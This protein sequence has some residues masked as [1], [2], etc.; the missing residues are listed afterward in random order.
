MR[1]LILLLT[2]LGLTVYA[3]L[4]PTQL[5]GGNES[6]LSTTFNFDLSNI[7]VTRN[8]TSVQFGTIP[9]TQGGTSAT[10]LTQYSLMSG[11]GTSAVN[12]IAPAASGTILFSNGASAF[13]SYRLLASS[14]ITTSLGY[15]PLASSTAAIISTL[16]YT[17][18][19]TGAVASNT[20]QIATNTADIATVSST[21]LRKANNLSDVASATVARSNL[22]LGSVATLNT[23]DLTANVSG[24]LPVT[25]GGTGLSTVGSSGTVFTSNASGTAEWRYPETTDIVNVTKNPSFEQ[26]LTGWTT[27]GTV[28]LTRYDRSANGVEYMPND[29]YYLSIDAASTGEAACVTDV[30]PQKLRGSDIEIGSI[31]R[32]GDSTSGTWTISVSAGTTVSQTISM[33]GATTASG[34]NDSFVQAPLIV[35]G[36]TSSTATIKT[37]YQNVSGSPNIHVDNVWVGS[38]KSFTNGAIV[39]PWQSYT[40]SCSGSWVTNATY[41]CKKRQVGDSMEYD[42]TVTLSGAPTAT[43]LVMNLPDTIDTNKITSTDANKTIGTASLISAG[44]YYIANPWYLTTTSVKLSATI[45]SAGATN[46]IINVSNTNPAT[47]ASG[48]RV[49]FSL[50]VPIVGLQATGVSYDSRCANDISCTNEFSAKIGSAGAVSDENGGMDWIN[51]NA[52]VTATSTYTVTLNAV[53]GAAPNCVIT[54]SDP[55]AS[56]I[57]GTEVT[58]ESISASTIV[59]RTNRHDATALPLAV[60]IQC[61][62][63]TDYKAKQTIQGYL[64]NTVTT[65][66]QYL[67]RMV[68]AKVGSSCT[69][70]P[71]TITSQS[72]EISSITRASTGNYT[73][74]FVTGTWSLAPSCI[75]TTGAQSGSAGIY[76]SYVAAPTTTS[77]NFITNSGVTGPGNLTDVS[78]D[79]ICIGPRGN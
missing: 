24:V 56:S 76:A 72:G 40:T 6:K 51:G 20:A 49:Y 64:S 11:N 62:R 48:D 12:M 66:G 5:K 36:T 52:A 18:A 46:N 78:F 19:S 17:P 32:N 14:D 38:K 55:T 30:I 67:E 77:G 58:I 50:K 63:S 35:V 7:P 71:C 29:R 26:N 42:I 73:F 57:N 22:G 3:N 79:I 2:L 60:N 53:F 15:T 47:F 39:G 27:S 21:M 41:I 65:G 16:G 31:Y 59:Y 8:G 75:I 23:V 25:N 54:T 61:S 69:S 28:T 68:R 33:A 43:D 70:T 1:Y 13:P 74:N 9:V 34:L 10:S 45:N 4:P 37:C 44:N